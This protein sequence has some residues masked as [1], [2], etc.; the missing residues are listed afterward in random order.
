MRAFTAII[1]AIAILGYFIFLYL[2]AT[3]ESPSETIPLPHGYKQ[4]PNTHYVIDIDGDTLKQE[5]SIRYNYQILTK[6][7]RQEL[8]RRLK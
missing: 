7:E 4:I 8:Y 6:Q 3:S 2:L 5:V 1:G